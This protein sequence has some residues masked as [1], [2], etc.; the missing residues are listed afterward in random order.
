MNTQSQSPEV[1]N[2]TQPESQ[3]S[4]L[5]FQRILVAVDYAASTPEVFEQAL[6]L[7]QLYGS[8]LMV[9]H[10]LQGQ[11][12]G[13]TE[14]IAS[15][16]IGAYSGVYTQEMI[17]LEEQVIREATEELQAWL[18][19]FVQL[20]KEKG[21]TA[22][23]DYQIGSPGKQIS[24]FAQT[25]GADLIVVGRRGRAGLSELLLGSVSNYIIHHAHCS[26]L[27]VQH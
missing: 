27:V 19:D 18:A 17:E 2:Q 24:D 7:A 12:P 4:S 16:G 8:R 15:V 3:A 20:A 13:I 9:F 6:R 26:V 21:V 22:E 10:C 5:G 14:T 23:S 11:V 1:L 25:W